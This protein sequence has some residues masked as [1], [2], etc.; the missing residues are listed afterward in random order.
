MV[1]QQF[2]EW[3]IEKFKEI[4]YRKFSKQKFKT[5]ISYIRHESCSKFN[6]KIHPGYMYCKTLEYWFK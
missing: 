1:N 6:M 5:P 4:Q 3:I 2:P